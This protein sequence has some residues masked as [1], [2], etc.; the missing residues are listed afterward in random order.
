[1]TRFPTDPKLAAAVRAV[2]MLAYGWPQGFRPRRDRERRIHR[3][4]IPALAILAGGLVFGAVL[5]WRLFG[6]SRRPAKARAFAAVEARDLAGKSEALLRQLREL[7]DTA[8]KRNPEQ[9]PVSD[10]RSSSRQRKRFSRSSE[11]EVR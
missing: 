3:R 2:R 4:L 9:S 7:E 11:R 5:V 6:G 10:T 1:V 8:S